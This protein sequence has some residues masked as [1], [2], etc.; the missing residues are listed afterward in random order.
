MY[1]IHNRYFCVS[2]SYLTMAYGFGQNIVLVIY[3]LKFIFV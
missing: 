2:F 3:L 1:D